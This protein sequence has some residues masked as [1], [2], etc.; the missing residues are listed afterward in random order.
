MK[1]LLITVLVAAILL[2]V[3]VKP[4]RADAAFNWAALA[5]VAVSLPGLGH[6]ALLV[7]VV[8]AGVYVGLHYDDIVESITARYDKIADYFDTLPTETKAEFENA[9]QAIKTDSDTYLPVSEAMHTAAI[10]YIEQYLQRQYVVPSSFA[11]PNISDG[12]SSNEQNSYSPFRINNEYQLGQT[13][14]LRFTYNGCTATEINFGFASC[15][16]N[17]PGP[18]YL[19]DGK[20]LSFRILQGT[21]NRT[22]IQQVNQTSSTYVYETTS[23]LDVNTV[24]NAIRTIEEYLTAMPGVTISYREQVY[25]DVYPEIEIPAPA[26][27]TRVYVPA[28]SI[29][30]PQQGEIVV[31][32]PDTVID[33]VVPKEYTESPDVPS[34][35]IIGG[36][37]QVF[38]PV[39]DFFKDGI[40]G[41]INDVN[42][43]ALKSIPATVTTKFPFS[44]PWDAGRALDA[45]FG[46]FTESNT[47]PIWQYVLEFRG[48]THVFN[49]QFP[50]LL[51]NWMPFIRAFILIGF[52]ISIIYAVRKLLGGAQ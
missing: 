32:I 18:L 41:N 6:A 36:I 33:Q 31:S 10:G 7:A 8:A 27:D 21:Q 37:A 12:C 47:P 3:T 19:P 5:P 13:N 2:N 16:W 34:E 25:K 24:Y 30:I 15:C 26:A 48:D 9:G 42:I 49:I 52:D 46:Q 4:Q 40:V 35:G 38:A 17:Y 22:Y 23:T 51:H 1:K 39:I 44:L 28:G 14:N 20:S 11:I 45:V 29:T 43:D 50:Q